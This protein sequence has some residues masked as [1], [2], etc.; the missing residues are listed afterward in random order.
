MTR[1]D[2][3]RHDAEHPKRVVLMVVLIL[4]WV[5]T[6]IAWTLLEW[7]G[8]SSTALRAVLGANI[9][10]HPV[11]FVIVRQRLL[12]QRIIDTSCLVFAAVICAGCANAMPS[13]E[14]LNANSR[15]V[16]DSDLAERAR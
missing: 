2:P 15:L 5:S 11:M 14:V 4:S 8:A 7:R 12:T 9:V 13:T 6:L 3:T 16:R 10:F 1:D